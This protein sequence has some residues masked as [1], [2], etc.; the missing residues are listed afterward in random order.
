MVPSFLKMN[1]P[2]PFKYSIIWMGPFVGEMVYSSL[3]Q[4]ESEDFA[5]AHEIKC[6]LL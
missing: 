1:S 4:M 5:G 3:M 6:C 2:V